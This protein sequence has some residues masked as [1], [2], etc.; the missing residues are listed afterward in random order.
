MSD[1]INEQPVGGTGCATCDD[2]GSIWIYHDGVRV[3]ITCPDCGGGSAAVESDDARAER[4]TRSVQRVDGRACGTETVNEERWVVVSVGCALIADT[5]N[6]VNARACCLVLK[7]HDRPYALWRVVAD[8]RTLIEKYDVPSSPIDEAQRLP[9]TARA[10][11]G[12]GSD[13]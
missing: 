9:E 6:E 3:P 4:G 5:T 2:E 1:M 7:R 10:P 12:E 8:E 13:V 11:R